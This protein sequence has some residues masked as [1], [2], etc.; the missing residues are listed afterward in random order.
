MASRFGVF[1]P[2]F[3]LVLLVCACTAPPQPV[4]PA[5][6][7]MSAAPSPVDSTAA[8]VPAAEVPAADCLLISTGEVVARAPCGSPAIPYEPADIAAAC[9]HIFPLDPNQAYANTRVTGD[10]AVWTFGINFDLVN[11]N[12]APIGCLTL[13]RSDDASRSFVPIDRGGI[14]VDTCS[15]TTSLPAIEDGVAFFDGSSD[16]TCTMNMGAWLQDPLLQGWV[17]DSLGELGSAEL[18]DRLDQ[19]IPDDF[20]IEYRTYALVAS[21]IQRGTPPCAASADCL[22]PLF[23][24]IPD[25]SVDASYRQKLS[26]LARAGGETF[27]FAS[28]PEACAEPPAWTPSAARALIWRNVPPVLPEP[29]SAME[30]LYRRAADATQVVC[31]EPGYSGFVPF[32]L[33]PAEVVIGRDVDSP[34][35]YV[36]ELDGIL[37]GPPDSKPPA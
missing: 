16:V 23:Q 12:G 35:T 24:L 26:V 10:I 33:G 3:A 9:N 28:G 13:L 25:P 6:P 29:I 11:A 19:A 8:E 4:Q 31:Y 5:E 17:R 36:G 2:V 15:T 34:A 21:L 7:A 32:W 37:I 18:A 14:L 22:Q 20:F 30:Y 1:P 27:T